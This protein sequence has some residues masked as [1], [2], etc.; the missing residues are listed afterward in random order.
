MNPLD[1]I[2]KYYTKDSDLYNI[3]INHSLDVTNKALEIVRKHP[4]LG[5]DEDFIREAGMLH[6]IGIFLTNAPSIQCFGNEPYIRHGVLGAEILRKEKLPRHALVCER[7]TGAGLTKDEIISQNL[8]LPH[9][10]M[11]PV[12]IEEEIICFADCF[13]SKTKLGQQKTIEKI[14]QKMGEHN[15]RSA[16]QVEVWAEKFL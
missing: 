11:M 8:P 6:D 9:T 10:E 1:I 16:K 3:L 5:A 14:I 2:E 4:E 7:H 15:E 13:F 12:S